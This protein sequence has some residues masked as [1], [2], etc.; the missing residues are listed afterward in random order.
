MLKISFA[1]CFGLSPAISVQFTLEMH[2]AAQNR[3][4]FTKTPYFGG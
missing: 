1:G 2:V 3:K 4:K